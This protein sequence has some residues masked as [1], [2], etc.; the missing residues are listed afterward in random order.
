M[1]FMQDNADLFKGDQ[2]QQML[3]AFESG[4]YRLI[5]EALRNNVN[6]QKRLETQLAQIDN[7]LSIEEARKGEERNEAYI[8]YL[9]E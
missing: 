1:E 4:N 8:K 6:Y 7:E 2:G 3:A 5:E 9:K